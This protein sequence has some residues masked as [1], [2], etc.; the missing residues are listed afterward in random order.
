[1][2]FT[3]ETNFAHTSTRRAVVATSATIWSQTVLH[4]ERPKNTDKV[5][6]RRSQSLQ[7]KKMG[8]TYIPKKAGKKI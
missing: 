7:R 3:E 8:T 6:T 5:N 1:M 4:Q 2:D